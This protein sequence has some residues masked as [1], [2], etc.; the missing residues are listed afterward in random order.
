MH[1]EEVTL[2]LFTPLFAGADRAISSLRVCLFSVYIPDKVTESAARL[3][4]ACG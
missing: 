1:S 2:P 4:R 3:T